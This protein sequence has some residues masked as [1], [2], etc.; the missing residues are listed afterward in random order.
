MMRTLFCRAT[1]V[2]G[3]YAVQNLLFVL[4][5]GMTLIGMATGLLTVTYIGSSWML[6]SLLG[7]ALRFSD[8]WMWQTVIGTL[9]GVLFTSACA[10]LRMLIDWGLF[11]IIAAIGR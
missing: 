6:G 9:S 5:I 10:G 2:L 3:S 7:P 8:A 11:A 4:S 1:A